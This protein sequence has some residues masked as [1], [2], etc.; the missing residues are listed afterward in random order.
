LSNDRQPFLQEPSLMS[1][2]LVTENSRNESPSREI[3]QERHRLRTL[4]KIHDFRSS[5]IFNELNSLKRS[6]DESVER[7]KIERKR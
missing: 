3:E 2:N 5:R 1:D 6:L 7:E 4:T